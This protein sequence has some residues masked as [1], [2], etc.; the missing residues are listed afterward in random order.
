[1]KLFKFKR[2]RTMRTIFLKAQ[3]IKLKA[4]S[5][6]SELTKRISYLLYHSLQ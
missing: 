2:F 3:G 1:M 4:K 6:C 5:Y